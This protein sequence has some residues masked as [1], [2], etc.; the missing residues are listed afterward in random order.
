VRTWRILLGVAGLGVLA[1][2]AYG[3]VTAPGTHPGRQ[4]LFMAALVLGHEGL[5]MPMA[6]AGGWVAVRVVPPWA[7]PAAQGALVVSLALTVIAIPFIVN[8]GRFPDNPTLLPLNYRRG[9]LV[10]IGVTWLVA[11]AVAA[12][13]WW[14]ARGS[15]AGRPDPHGRA[16]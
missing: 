1:Y 9:L 5:L 12:G 16:G 7:R 4:I 8:A 11:A 3:L 14:R 15:D 10:A 13:S 6:L 2:G